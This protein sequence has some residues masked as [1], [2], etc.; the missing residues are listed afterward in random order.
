MSTELLERRAE[1]GEPRGAANIW[2]DTQ[3]PTPNPGG[4][5]GAWVFR[6]ALATILIAAG[7][8]VF[9]ALGNDRPASTA[10]QPADDASENPLP[11]PLL[12]DGT[13]LEFFGRTTPTWQLDDWGAVAFST[14]PSSFSA[15]MIGI[16]RSGGVERRWSANIESQQQLDELWSEV[17]PLG[18]FNWDVVPGSQVIVASWGRASISETFEQYWSFD[19]GDLSL[20]VTPVDETL[21]RYFLPDNNPIETP[22]EPALLSFLVNDVSA[23]FANLAITE[24]DVDV[25]GRSGYLIDQSTTDLGGLG[26]DE[27][28]RNFVIWA[29]GE[30]VYQLASTDIE[31][32]LAD[33]QL[34]DREAWTTAIDEAE[35]IERRDGP[36]LANLALNWLLLF[37]LGG[38]TTALVFSRRSWPLGVKIALLVVIGVAASLTASP[39]SAFNAGLIG[40]VGSSWYVQRTFEE[41]TTLEEEQQPESV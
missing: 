8:A 36:D 6:L 17:V 12:I 24:I 28:A 23:E 16:T 32:S 37:P 33:L 21:W 29:D 31:A 13:P 4:P 1:R 5:R 26:V 20:L 41:E 40:A 35:P 27:A 3:T 22:A 30:F 39:F 7:I 19:F 11:A 38:F 10:T 15:P 18:N 2:A 25:V 9:G 34:V 14:D